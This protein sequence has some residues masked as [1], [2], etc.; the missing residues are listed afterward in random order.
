M[1]K[2]LITL[3]GLSAILVATVTFFAFTGKN[4]SVSPQNVP[5]I[6][7]HTEYAINVDNPD[8]IVSHADLTFVATVIAQDKTTYSDKVPLENADGST[9]M[10]GSAYTHYTVDV[11]KVLKGKI[12]CGSIKIVKT[13][14]IREDKSAINVLEG[15]FMPKV[16]RT[17][18]FNAYVQDDGTILLSGQNSNVAVSGGTKADI[19][20]DD[21]VATYQEA[22]RK[23]K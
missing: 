4:Q 15:D 19:A 13:G 16:G 17:Y 14:G 2:Q 6:E 3:I 20:Q 23:T 9:T 21:N 10:V 11:L 1:K 12:S 22:A 5:V 7:A 18:V 8:V